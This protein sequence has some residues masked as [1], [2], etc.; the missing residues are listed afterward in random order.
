M[1]T[2]SPKRPRLRPLALAPWAAML[3]MAAMWRRRP[4]R[5][6][7]RGGAPV[8]RS[9][10]VQAGVEEIRLREPGRGRGAENPM[11]IPPRGWLDVVWRVG[12]EVND[13]RLPA[14]AGG[15]TF[16]ILLAIFPGLGV[17][18]SLYGLFADVS[19]AQ[20]QFVSLIGIFPDAFLTIIGEQMIRLASAPAQN[21]S[22]AFVV[23]LLLAI[24]S[25][26][27]GVRALMDGL[28]IAYDEDEKRGFVHLRLMALGATVALLL[29]ILFLAGLLVALP[30]LL[31]N[32]N[33]LGVVVRWLAALAMTTGLFSI[34]YRY[35]PSRARPRWQWVTWG[36]AIAA[37]LWMAGSLGFSAY[38]TYFANF[39]RTY[40]PLGA[41]IAFMLWIWFSVLV[42]LLGAEVNAEVEHQTA[43]DS[44]TGPPAPMGRRGAAMADTIGL[45]AQVGEAV[46]SLIER[47]QRIVRPDTTPPTDRK[48][49]A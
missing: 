12:K 32:D 14:V 9:E 18:V 3:V 40:G 25:A 35:G 49:P 16:Y 24:S 41:V 45:R 1:S 5:V 6:Q 26:S 48:G 8:S 20:E 33:A 19:L 43:A 44:T 2:P 22:L 21:L 30:A 7:G 27:A 15:I 17:F 13:D 10:P 47:L 46:K 39:D 37:V 29:S 28:N 4:G 31:P 36:S 42:L 38:V 23:S 11:Q 34:I